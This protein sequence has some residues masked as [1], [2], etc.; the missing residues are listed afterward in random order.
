V[1][2]GLFSGFKPLLSYI[3]PTLDQVWVGRRIFEAV[4]YK[5]KEVYLPWYVEHII[6][7]SKWI[8]VGVKSFLV[9]RMVGDGMKTFTGR[10]KTA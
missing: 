1:N 6:Y 4:V 9:R 5:E 2:T 10:P 3:L 8:P 7:V